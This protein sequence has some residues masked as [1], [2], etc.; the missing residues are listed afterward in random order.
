MDKSKITVSMSLE[1]FEAIKNEDRYKPI[2]NYVN[3]LV[4]VLDQHHDVVPKRF[5]IHPSMRNHQSY[6]SNAIWMGN[7]SASSSDGLD[8]K[9][10]KKELRKLLQDIDFE[11]SFKL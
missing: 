4:D 7:N 6:A 5:D 9:Q 1:E 10:V 11:K 2:L 3:E 8:L